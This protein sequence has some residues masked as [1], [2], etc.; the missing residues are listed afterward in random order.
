MAFNARLAIE[1]Q[2]AGFLVFPLFRSP[3]RP[4]SEPK[5][6]QRFEGGLPVDGRTVPVKGETPATNL[7]HFIPVWEKNPAIIG[8]GVCAPHHLV[9]D[10]DVKNNKNGVDQFEIMREKYQI[11]KPGF[12]VK[13]KSGGYH[14]YYERSDALKGAMIAKAVNMTMGQMEQYLGVDLVANNGYVVG[15]ESNDPKWVEGHY[16]ILKGSLAEMTVCPDAALAKQIR[17]KGPTAPTSGEELIE[18]DADDETENLIATIRSARIPEVIPV[19]NRDNLLT[20]FIGVLKSRKIPMETAEMLC[21]TFLANCELNSDETR[22]MFIQG[23]DLKGKLTRFYGALA[24]SSDPRVVARHLVIDGGVYKCLEQLPGSIALVATKENPYMEKF[25]IYTETKARQDLLPYTKPIPDSDN[26]KPVNP[27]D[28]LLRDSSVPRV[29]STG[30]YPKAME[31]FIEPSDGSQRVNLYQPPVIPPIRGRTNIV[32][33]VQELAKDLC[34]DLAD[35]VLDFMAHIVQKPHVKM[36]VAVLMISVNQGT[37][38]NTLIQVLKPLIGASNYLSVPGLMPL[39]EDKSVI[40]EGNVLIVFNEVARPSNRSQW[41]DMSKAVNKIK[42]SITDSSTHINP[43]YE[44]QRKITSYSNFFMLSNDP[45]PF[46]LGVDDRRIVVVNNNPPKMDK[47]GRMKLLGD[48]AHNDKNRQLSQ[49]QYNDLTAELY[50][51]FSTRQI[52]VNLE[53]GSAPMSEAKKDMVEGHYTP[54]VAALQQLRDM[55]GLG[56]IADITSEEKLIYVIRH[57]LGFK[58][59]GRDRGKYDIFGAFI[60]AR[61]IERAYQKDGK[62]SK[63]LVGAPTLLEREDFPLVAPVSASKSP[64]KLYLFCNRDKDWNQASDGVIRE[65]LWK[66]LNGLK[67]NEGKSDVA[68]LIK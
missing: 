1:F 22:E 36:N 31:V 23:I 52:E 11:P 28:I 16:H 49:E 66:D 13:S 54:P 33:L 35:Y 56:A 3:S 17:V 59:F 38:K 7:P 20:V 21:N 45:T 14:L 55:R 26:A 8:Y 24:N 42:T 15:P 65:E 63:I 50:E 27:L 12:V 32:E 60:Q 4:F 29:H 39:V 44:K 37:G 41:T 62:R 68:S 5:G 47:D 34:G 30:Y 9:F 64:Q 18:F 25:V 40:L 10:L 67:A 19:G 48:F 53:H 61:V 2:K 6:W 43:K 58:E 51:F 57:V 46:D